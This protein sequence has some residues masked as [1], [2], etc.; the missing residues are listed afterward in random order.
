MLEPN[1]CAQLASLSPRPANP[2]ASPRSSISPPGRPTPIDVSAVYPR[3][4]N[5]NIRSG[6]HGLNRLRDLTSPHQPLLQPLHQNRA[7]RLVR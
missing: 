7:P 3:G 4:W 2:H 1:V 6:Q 5:V